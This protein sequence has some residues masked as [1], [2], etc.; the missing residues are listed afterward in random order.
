MT[1]LDDFRL[2]REFCLAQG[3]SPEVL[4][5]LSDQAWEKTMALAREWD[6]VRQDEEDEPPEIAEARRKREERVADQEAA[7]TLF[8]SCG[9]GAD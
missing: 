8:F 3:I 2:A 9:G 7:E 1:L 4:I 6:S 5:G